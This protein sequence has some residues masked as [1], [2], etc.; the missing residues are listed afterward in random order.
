MNFNP[1]LAYSCFGFS[2][3]DRHFEN[4]LQCWC[5]WIVIFSQIEI[6]INFKILLLFSFII[7]VKFETLKHWNQH[8]NIEINIETLKTLNRIQCWNF[9]K[10]WHRIEFQCSFFD[11]ENIEL[12][13]MSMSVQTL[14]LHS[15]PVVV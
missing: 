14:S 2:N 6:I 3:Q 7:F 13:S 11:I 9:E 10:H 12:K 8:W 1:N 4:S 5:K 15:P